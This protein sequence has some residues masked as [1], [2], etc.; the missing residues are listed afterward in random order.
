MRFAREG[1]LT[2]TTIL[3]VIFFIWRLDFGWPLI[4]LWNPLR[5]LIF[6]VPAPTE[7]EPP[8]FDAL[9]R[10]ARSTVSEL[11]RLNAAQFP[12]THR[13]SSSVV[14]LNLLLSQATHQLA[15]R[16][17]LLD[18]LSDQ[19][20]RRERQLDALGS[21][22]KHQ[23]ARL[24]N[25]PDCS[26]SH[27]SLEDGRFNCGFGCTAHH[28]AYRL[29]RAYATN[30]TL[31]LEHDYGNDFFLPLSNCSKA[32]IESAKPN[33]QR[34]CPMHPQEWAKRL[35]EI[36]GNPI[37]WYRGHLLSYILRPRDAVL[38]RR[39]EIEMQTLRTGR[40]GNPYDGPIAGIH[41]RRT[42]KIFV[43]AT[44]HPLGEYMLHVERFFEVKEIEYCLETGTSSPPFWSQRRRVFLASDDASVFDEARSNYPR[45]EFIGGL[46]KGSEYETRRSTTGVFAIT[47]DINLL[48]ASDF[49]VCTA[50]SNICRLVYELFLAK[51][52]VH[53]DATFQVQ[54]VDE[55]YQRYFTLRRWWRAI[56][57]LKQKGIKLG[58]T[59]PISSTLWDGFVRTAPTILAPQETSLPAY[60]FQEIV[61]TVE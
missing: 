24:Q 34:Y 15:A 7:R 52:Q 54:S 19:R 39:L 47:L 11:W 61:Q 45:Y 1:G 12:P 58:D 17:S 48:V 16:L 40:N 26:P 22:L 51:P 29:A 30:R 2:I 27:V 25:P 23:I 13:N 3:A 59:I 50:T 32:Q 60:L 53:G 9:L 57:D 21:E 41:V 20:E 43:E 38:R 14:R 10:Q 33:G 5:T 56:A 36:Q 18:K 44:F 31:M 4:S 49:V 28:V 55:I 37:A 35:N 6:Y 46:R 42:D 8:N